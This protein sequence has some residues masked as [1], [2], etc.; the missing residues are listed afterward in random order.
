[1]KMRDLEQKISIRTMS[2]ETPGAN[3]QGAQPLSVT[4]EFPDSAQC[5]GSEIPIDHFCPTKRILVYMVNYR[6]NKHSSLLDLGNVT[7]F[8]PSQAYENTHLTFSVC[9]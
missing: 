6:C 9:K 1:M 7:S 8:F 2:L 4:F 5:D 3:M